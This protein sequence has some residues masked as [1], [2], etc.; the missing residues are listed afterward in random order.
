M[1]TKLEKLFQALAKY[2]AFDHKKYS[3]EEFF[4]DLKTFKDGLQVRSYEMNIMA[5]YDFSTL[6]SKKEGKNAYCPLFEVYAFAI[7]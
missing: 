1:H 3:M 6:C 7:M 4:G 2:F 5:F